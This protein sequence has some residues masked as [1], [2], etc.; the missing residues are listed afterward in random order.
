MTKNTQP[1]DIAII[2]GGIAGLS[3]A[4]DLLNA[5]HKVTIYEGSSST[6][7]LASGAPISTMWSA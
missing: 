1:L 6:G 2:G 4:Y 3:A 7:G 5:G